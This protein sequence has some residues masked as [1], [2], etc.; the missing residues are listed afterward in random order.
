MVVAPEGTRSTDGSIGR[1][2]KGAFHLAMQAGR[3]VV[4][5]VLANSHAVM[6]QG[7]RLIHAATVR[8][9]VHEPIATETWSEETLD[10]E[11]NKIEE[12]FRSPVGQRDSIN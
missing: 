5:V 7:G 6:P 9:V 1:F 12:L 2:K 4:P 8:V 10:R 3:P 11:V